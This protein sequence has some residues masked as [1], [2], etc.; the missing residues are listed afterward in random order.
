MS[1]FKSVKKAVKQTVKVA[2]KPVAIGTSATLQAVGARHAAEKLGKKAGLSEAERRI[3]KVGGTVIDV[4]AGVL[5]GAAVAPALGHG[6]V[7]GA[8][9]LKTGVGGI[10]TKGA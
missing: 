2:V 8:T 1:F 6:A 4:G 5:V 9:A 7:A 10:L 3:A